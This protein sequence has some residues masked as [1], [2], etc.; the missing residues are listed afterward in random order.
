MAFLGCEMKFKIM[1]V[2]LA[3]LCTSQQLYADCFDALENDIEL[4][5][6][7][8]K[9]ALVGSGGQ[10]FGMLSNENY[11]TS[12]EKPVI[13]KW[14]IKREQCVNSRPLSNDPVEQ[15]QREAFNAGQSLILD[16]YKGAITYGQFASRRQEIKKLSD[17]KIQAIIGQYQQQQMQQQQYQQQQEEYLYQACMNRA[18]NQFD[19]SNC[20]M[21]R[22][23]RNIGRM[24]TR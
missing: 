6:I 16:L 9:V 12:D 3:L 11:P 10:T 24:L 23:G 15:I 5:V 20:G 7:R 14:A 1:L 22:S 2:L 17:A 18:R 4:Q 13:Y 21:E 8:D 19:Q